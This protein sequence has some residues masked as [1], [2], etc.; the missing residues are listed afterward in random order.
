MRRC[1]D[2]GSIA[3]EL[4]ASLYMMTVSMEAAVSGHAGFQISKTARCFEAFYI[5]NRLWNV[6][7]NSSP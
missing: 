6:R 5:M 4:Q 3:T 2:Q 1:T 7:L